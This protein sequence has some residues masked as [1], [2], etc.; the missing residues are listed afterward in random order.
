MDF[1]S[2]KVSVVIPTYNRA[3]VIRRSMHS[4]LC[5]TYKNIEV[6]VVDD[7]S[8]DDTSEVVASFQDP[9]VIFLRQF[10]RKGA[11]V[12]R[13]IGIQAAS[14]EFI[15]FQDSDDEWLCE[16][17]ERQMS[18]MQHAAET[19]GVVY[20]GFLRFEN[21]FAK[22]LPSGSRAEIGGRI[23][24]ALLRGNFV[25]TQAVLIRK[26]CLENVGM[27]DEQ[28]P[29]LQDWELFIRL[30]VHYDFI[31]IDEPLLIAFHSQK[32]IT[33][34]TSLFPVAL[35]QLLEK[36]EKLFLSYPAS[37]AKHYLVLAYYE[38]RSGRLLHGV[39]NLQSAARAVWAMFY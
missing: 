26:G 33:A 2:P 20:S 22:Y 12:A 24:A 19:V 1:V 28:F 7:A 34:D 16:K 32:S 37:M 29:R 18:A 31:C 3:D 17:L 21:K 10:E 4:V 13:N 5:Q 9:R 11:A 27:F 8:T 35:K 14:G 23:L 15:A 30:A 38:F 6:I 39:S 25:T 36:H